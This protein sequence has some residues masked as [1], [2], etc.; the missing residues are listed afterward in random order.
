VI[1]TIRHEIEIAATPASVYA[2]FENIQENYTKWHPDHIVFR[3]TRGDGLVEGAV[4]YSEQRIHGKV[5]GMPVRFTKVVPAKRVEFELTNPIARFF[6]P[7]Y[8]WLFEETEGGCRFV[9]EGDVRLGGIV[10]RL[11][12]VQQALAAGRRHLAEEGENLKRLVESGAARGG[13]QAL[14]SAA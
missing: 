2:F 7:R 8:L 13:H 3:W 6:A 9:A 12:H 14:S 10:S 11:R 5:H 1:R 4:A